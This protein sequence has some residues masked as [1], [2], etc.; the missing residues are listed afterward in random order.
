MKDIKILSLQVET[1]KEAERIEKEILTKEE[2]RSVEVTKEMDCELE[3]RIREYEKMKAK[4]SMPHSKAEAGSLG[5]AEPENSDFGEAALERDKLEK[6]SSED[7]SEKITGTGKEFDS[8]TAE[9]LDAA[10]AARLLL[11]EEDRKALEIGRKELERRK[12]HGTFRMPGR[13]RVLVALAAILVL[14]F[15][16]GITGVGSKSYWKELWQRLVGKQKTTVI[17]V[18]D[19]EM[20][21]SEDNEQVGYYK[22]IDETLGIQSIYP[23]KLPYGTMVDMVEIDETQRM[24]KIIYSYNGHNILYAVYVNDMNSSY[25]EKVEDELTDTFEVQTDKQTITVEE[26]FIEET[27]EYRYVSYFE[28]QGIHYQL[29]GILDREEFVSILENL[30]YY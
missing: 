2:L 7:G 16:V 27:K 12:R 23:W 15:A 5:K 19:M 3:R 26:Y 17:N 9:E 29:M 22:E 13:R 18:E 28:Y 11:S 6:V 24:A 4:R 30:Y 1:D 20:Q 25:S 10:D 8:E 21:E 14:L